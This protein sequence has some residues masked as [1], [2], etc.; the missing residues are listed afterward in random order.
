MAVSK[1]EIEEESP[2]ARLNGPLANGEAIAE[3]ESARIVCYEGERIYFSPIEPEDEPQFRRW[4]NDPVNW[5]YLAARPPLNAC[6][7]R[8]WI[9]S[10]GKS[11]ND[12]VF[13]VVVR[14]G[15]R[16]IGAT[17]LHRIDRITRKAELGISLG[18]RA[19]RNRGYGTEAVRLLVRYG[20]E[21]LNLNRISLSV[22]AHNPRAIRCY[23]KAGFVQEG[24]HR[25][26]C[27]QGGRYHD[28]YR[29]AVLKD[30]W[31]A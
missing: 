4:I 25:Q 27:Y 7:E 11:Q 10:Q 26:A 23:Q 6:R 21:E 19:A 8:E 31:E 15:H 9:E 16:L 22:I 12:V 28:V 29:F 13:G 18:D 5:Q 14:E 2:P 30:E 24:C 3:P 1:V 17:G 20:F